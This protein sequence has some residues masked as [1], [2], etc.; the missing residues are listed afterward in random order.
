MLGSVAFTA[1]FVLCVVFLATVFAELSALNK[2]AKANNLPG[3]SSNVLKSSNDA[4]RLRNALPA[5][6]LRNRIKW[7]K[8]VGFVCWL[9]VIVLN[10]FAFFKR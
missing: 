4:R 6:E 3:I 10:G 7:L 9:I 5:G 2:F 8:A 1:C